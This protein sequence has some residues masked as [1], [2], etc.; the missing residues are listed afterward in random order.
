LTLFDSVSAAVSEFEP[1]IERYIEGGYYAEEPTGLVQSI[2]VEGAT[3]GAEVFFIDRLVGTIAGGDLLVPFT[4]FEIGTPL[5]VRITKDGYHDVEELYPLDEPRVTISA[6]ELN[7]ETRFDLALQWS[8]GLA[9]GLGVGARFHLVPDTTFL[10]LD[11]Y[12]T[13]QPKP[14]PDARNVHHYDT[15]ASIGRYFLFSY[16]SLVRLSLSAGFGMIVS[17]VDDLDGREYMDWY[18]LVGNPTVELNLDRVSFFARPELKYALGW[19]Y[20]TLGRV[21]IRTGY[22]TNSGSFSILPITVGARYSW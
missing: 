11:H 18:I 10:A 12:R 20:N 22:E 16:R 14:T 15:S 9:T 8:F 1:V 7:R 5:R 21:W 6:R 2:T 13:F 17:D 4:Q 3:E 19:G